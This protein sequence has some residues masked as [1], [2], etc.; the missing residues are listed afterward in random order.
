MERQN[1]TTQNKRSKIVKKVVEIGIASRSSNPNTNYLILHYPSQQIWYKRV[2][3]VK[4][5]WITEQV[6]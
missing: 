4:V 1:L 5:Q 6:W 2:M 3:L